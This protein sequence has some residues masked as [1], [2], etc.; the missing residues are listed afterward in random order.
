MAEERTCALSIAGF[1]PSGG[2]GI[3]ADIK[4][5]EAYQICGLG[6]VSA[7]TFQ[8][9][10][11]FDGVNWIG[12]EEI[13]EQVAVL[14]RRFEFRFIKIG[15]MKDLEM[16]EAICAHFSRRPLAVNLIWDPVVKASAGF[17]FHK[18]MD[19]QKLAVLLKKCALITPNTDEVK[20]L[21]GNDNAM[22]AARELS[23]YCNVLL[24]GGHRED[25]PGADYLFSGSKIEKMVPAADSLISQK[26]GSGCVLSSAITANLAKGSTLTEACRNGK[27]YVE[28]FLAS[29]QTLLGVH[30]AQ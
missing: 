25:E 19:R 2:A 15:L 4:T 3:L 29:N 28:R 18:G 23:A 6:A 10:A 5:F 12:I 13:L 22:E 30:Y 20:F 7:I 27:K 14:Q 24:T 1:D 8:N 16:L 11:A 9:D 26:H 17:E 21:T